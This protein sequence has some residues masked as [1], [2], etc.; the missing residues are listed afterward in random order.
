L[1]NFIYICLKGKC[2]SIIA[3]VEYTNSSIL[4][5]KEMS[6]INKENSAEIPVIIGVAGVIIALAGV[7]IA[8]FAIPH[9][10]DFGI[11]ID[12]M[13]LNVD[14]GSVTQTSV[15]ASFGLLYNKDLSL[16]AESLPSGIH[17]QFGPD[18]LTKGDKSVSKVTVTIEKNVN[19]DDYWIPIVCTGSDG[20]EHDCKLKLHVNNNKQISTTRETLTTETT[21]PEIKITYPLND[22][23]VQMNEIAKGTAKNVTE[24]QTLW[25]LVYD[26]NNYFPQGTVQ[27][28][29]EW[30][31]RIRIGDP[32]HHDIKFEI[33]A[34]LADKEAHS[35][36]AEHFKGGD[37]TAIENLP[38]GVKRYANVT[39]ERE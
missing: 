28:P 31:R 20:K 13:T 27:T 35:I 12:P 24:G 9:I 25:I 37:S 18:F 1:K 10:F 36:L 17:V 6:K 29:G 39:V 7:I 34:V 5:W 26:Y 8:F 11:S 16:R 2:L 3:K 33:D 22:T 32:Q 14:P 19:S 23:K 4:E 21:A 15:T 30:Q 38:P